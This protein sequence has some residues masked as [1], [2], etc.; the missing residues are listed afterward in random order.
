MLTSY[1]KLCYVHVISTFSYM[2]CETMVFI[3]KKS[4]RGRKKLVKHLTAFWRA[5]VQ[6]QE[7]MVTL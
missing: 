3:L 6:K 1:V 2:Q 4:F 5:K 7:I